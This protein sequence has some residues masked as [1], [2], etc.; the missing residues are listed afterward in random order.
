MRMRQRSIARCRWLLALVAFACLPAEARAQCIMFDEP[1]ELFAHSTMVFRGTVISTESTGLE[2]DHQIVQIATFRVRQSWKG[3]SIREVRVGADRAFEKSREYLVFAA[4]KPLTTSLLCRW[5]EPVRAA[6]RK[7]D[8]L[9]K[10]KHAWP[11]LKPVTARFT[12][13]FAPNASS[14]SPLRTVDNR[15]GSASVKPLNLI[16]VSTFRSTV[17]AQ[18]AKGVLDE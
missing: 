4:G 12:S 17:D 9:S 7:L 5:A 6:K 15:T 14:S 8:W 3:D 11:K 16:V 10:N 1:E 13:T 18:I 2:G